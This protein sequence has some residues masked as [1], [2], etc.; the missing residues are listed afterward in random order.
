MITKE[1]YDQLIAYIRDKAGIGAEMPLTVELL[2]E[3]DLGV[4]G[5]DAIE[6]VAGYAERFN[7]DTRGL[8]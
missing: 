1:L 5:D 4:T 7:V 8:T 3:D 6:L 2:I